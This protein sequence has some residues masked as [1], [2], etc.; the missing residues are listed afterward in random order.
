[1]PGCGD[2]AIPLP[3]AWAAFFVVSAPLRDRPRDWSLGMY[4]AA[5]STQWSRFSLPLPAAGVALLEERCRD[6][7]RR[8]PRDQS[9]AAAERSRNADAAQ[10]RPVEISECRHA[11][12]VVDHDLLVLDADQAIVAQLAQRAV[13]V[14]DA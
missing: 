13:D 8:L 5:T 4:S 12:D 6:D 3:F 11:V 7:D 14:R 1:M 10:I 2:L 9:G